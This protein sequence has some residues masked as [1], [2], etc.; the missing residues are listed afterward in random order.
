MIF[1]VF[2]NTNP[3]VILWQVISLTVFEADVN[4]VGKKLSSNLKALYNF[5]MN[6]AL[7][8]QLL[9][10]D[11]HSQGRLKISAEIWLFPINRHLLDPYP[12]INTSPDTVV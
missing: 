11:T 3:S 7:K 10:W 2:S 9:Q 12:G 6:K 1:K 5:Q 4:E 8:Y